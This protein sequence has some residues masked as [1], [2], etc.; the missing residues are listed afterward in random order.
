MRFRLV[1]T[2]DQANRLT[3]HCAQARFIWNLSLEQWHYWRPGRP[4]P[5]YAELN[6]QLTECRAATPW[7][8]TGSVVVQQQALRDFDQAKRNFFRGTHRRPTW[9]KK[10]RDEGFRIVAM[11]PS[12]LKRLNRHWS[13]MFVPKTGWVRFRQTRPIPDGVKSYRVTLDRVGRWHIALAHVPAPINGPGDGSVVGLDRGV[14][15]TIATSDGTLL[16]MP[17]AKETKRAK[18]LQ[19][20]LARRVKGS[21]NRRRLRRAVAKLFARIAHRRRDWIEKSTTHLARHYDTLVLEDLRVKAMTASARGTIEAPGRSVRQKAGLN[22]VI[23]HAAW[24]TIQRRL[25][26]KARDRVVLVPAAYTS[27]RCSACGHT[28][29]ENRESQA[30]FRCRACGYTV[31]ADIN[32]A[33]NLAAGHAVTARGGLG[34]STGPANRE[35]QICLL[36]A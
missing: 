6:R 36:S 13:A 21:R 23:L 34:C 2:P 17:A 7:L 28:A 26:D 31:H 1:P 33:K 5:G 35:P 25:C 8:A 19:R 10:G 18:T 20:K 30:T 12:H 14:T 9:R 29:P 32:A 11:V 24:S 3:E 22:R 27:L 15:T 16:T 4:V